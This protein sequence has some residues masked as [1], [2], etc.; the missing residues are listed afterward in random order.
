MPE[1][2]TFFL[3]TKLIVSKLIAPK[4]GSA[5]GHVASTHLAHTNSITTLAAHHAT[6][7][8]DITWGTNT[9]VSKGVTQG[10]IATSGAAFS[11]VKKA[12]NASHHKTEHQTWTL[13]YCQRGDWVNF[14]FRVSFQEAGQ[15]LIIEGYGVDPVGEFT[16]TG[17]VTKEYMSFLKSHCQV[18]DQGRH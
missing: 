3:L 17:K 18:L 6:V 14:S 16:V 5:A 10:I 2:F 13:A 9:L 12:N 11:S 7:A 15:N 1:P 8:H 4:V